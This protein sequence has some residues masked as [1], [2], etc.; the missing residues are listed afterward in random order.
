MMGCVVS[1]PVFGPNR[2]LWSLWD[3]VRLIASDMSAATFNLGMVSERI[4]KF[5]KMA[6]D[7]GMPTVTVNL[8]HIDTVHLA[9]QFLQKMAEEFSFSATEGAATRVLDLLDRL[10]IVGDK[11]GATETQ[12]TQ[13]IGYALYQLST[14]LSDELRASYFLRVPSEM[15]HFL[16]DDAS[17]FGADIDTKFPNAV[18]DMSEAAKCLALARYTACVF[19][20]MR[21]MEHCVQRLGKKLKVQANVKTDNWYK[22]ANDINIAINAMPGRTA[23]Q[24]A[25]KQKYALAYSNLNGVRMAWRNDVMHPKATYTE[26]E[27]RIVFSHVGAFLESLAPLI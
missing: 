17:A 7:A 26:D 11:Q 27:A 15:A 9:T 3:M 20:L 21:V 13:Q 8:E 19:H 23:A 1:A 24:N 22:I 14:T 5:A 4:V 10:L 25:K 12:T 6:D 2:R 16:E 18:E